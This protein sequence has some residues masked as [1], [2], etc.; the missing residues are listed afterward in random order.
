ME[1]AD[2]AGWLQRW[3]L[4]L[5][6]ATVVAA[7]SGFAIAVTLP[8]VYESQTELLVG[9]VN[10]DIETVRASGSLADTYV[11]LTLRSPVLTAAARRADAALT[12]EQLKTNVRAKANGLTRIVTIV[13]RDKSRSMAAKLANALATELI[14]V[15]D[16]PP[17]LPQGS[18]EVIERAR[19]APD[20][21]FPKLHVIVPLAAMAGLAGAIIVI[22]I[23]EA[24][25]DRVR[26]AREA[27]EISGVECIATVP[28]IARRTRRLG[29]RGKP[30]LPQSD[31]TVAYRLLATRLESA[32]GSTSNHRVLIVEAGKKAGGADVALNLAATLGAAGKQSMVVDAGAASGWL[33]SWSG[34]DTGLPGVWILPYESNGA[35]TA[36]DAGNVVEQLLERSDIVILASPPPDTDHDA[37][38]WARV[39]DTVVVV[40]STNSTRRSDL[41]ETIRGLRVIGADILGTV[42]QRPR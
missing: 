24:L 23:V 27:E 11:E 7:L 40:A 17:V 41:V 20:I 38:T 3:R 19:P 18:L 4:A 32:N 1:L 5:V 31:S 2:L 35:L 15:S 34:Q 9:P 26:D 28:P 12:L 8:P 13:V 16:R 29:A 30:A 6:T 22:V 10:A 14:A 21:A 39:A 42:L 25:S 37:F 36:D 33:S